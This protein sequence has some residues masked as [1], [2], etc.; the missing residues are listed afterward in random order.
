MLSRGGFGMSVDVLPS[1]VFTARTRMGKN[2]IPLIMSA[3][4]LSSLRDVAYILGLV[5][6]T[7][8][9]AA[10]FGDGNRGGFSDPALDKLIEAAIMRS[11]AGRDA[12]LQEAQ[13]ETVARL[14]MIPMYSEFTIAAARSGITYTPR[15]DQQ[16]VAQGASPKGTP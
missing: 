3:I 13:K 15:M 2:D 16:L 8:D 5:A 10:G 7:P 6:H 9:D 1:S 12:A 11:D 14:G 4:S